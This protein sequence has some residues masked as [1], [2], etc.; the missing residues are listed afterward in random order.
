VRHIKP[1]EERH[2]PPPEVRAETPGDGA[3][4]EPSL[5]Q[6][7]GARLRPVSDV[8]AYREGD[9]L[10]VRVQESA[11]A[12]RD[13]NTEI[14][15][16]ASAQ[17]ALDRFFGLLSR[18]QAA[19]IQP[20][21]GGSSKLSHQAKGSTSRS[22]NVEAT[23]PATVRKV[24]SNGNLFIEGHRVILVNEEEQHFYISGIVRPIDIEQ[25][26]SVRSDRIAEAEIEFTGRGVIT[27]GQREGWLSRFIA[28]IW[29]F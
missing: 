19:G 18:L 14:A 28:W 9:L 6:R 17:L 2:R 15:R 26:N 29:P 22:E 1:Y 25:D 23:V 5:W 11:S 8:R 10:V 20:G 27:E 24:L 3:E 13:A 12:Q 21:L 16:D 4:H 7:G